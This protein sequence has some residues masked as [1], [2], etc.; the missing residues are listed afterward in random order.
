MNI[1]AGH[2]ISQIMVP[3]P[4]FAH[5]YV[6]TPLLSPANYI[7]LP[8]IWT[9]QR[10]F[11][12]MAHVVVTKNAYPVATAEWTHDPPSPPGLIVRAQPRVMGEVIFKSDKSES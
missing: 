1:E 5:K 8:Q 2:V 11:S 6:H 10:Q 12:K 4:I 9:L 3:E 7:L